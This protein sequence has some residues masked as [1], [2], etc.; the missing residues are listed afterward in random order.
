MK[1]GSISFLKE[2]DRL[3]TFHLPDAHL[4]S[5]LI[6]LCI[7]QVTFGVKPWLRILSCLI[8]VT[9]DGS[10]TMKLGSHFGVPFWKLLRV[11]ESLSNATVKTPALVDVN[12]MHRGNFTLYT[13]VPL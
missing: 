8:L 11:V 13:V 1:L 2:I 6:G 10:R 9:G 3:K 12:E 4:S 7:K 5:M